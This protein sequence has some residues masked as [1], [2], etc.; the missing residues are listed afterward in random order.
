VDSAQIEGVELR[1]KMKDGVTF[2]EHVRVARGDITTPLSRDELAA[3]FM[4]QIEFS[5][6]IDK[7]KAEKLLG[8]LEKLEK[9]DDVNTIIALAVRS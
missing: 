7:R 6:T 3:K 8:I 2:S 1:L 4:T 5:Q 9:V